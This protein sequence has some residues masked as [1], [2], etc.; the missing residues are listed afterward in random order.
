MHALS[1]IAELLFVLYCESFICIPECTEDIVVKLYSSFFFAEM[2]HVEGP[3]H[4][5]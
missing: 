2:V 1:V 4:M 5:A 3:Y